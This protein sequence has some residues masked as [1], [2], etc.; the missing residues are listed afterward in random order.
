MARAQQS[1]PVTDDEKT[2]HLPA[3]YE[4]GLSRCMAASEES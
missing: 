2:V 4:A 3:L 1:I